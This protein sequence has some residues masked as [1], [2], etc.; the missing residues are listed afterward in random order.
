MV[1]AEEFKPGNY[2]L[3]SSDTSKLFK[4]EEIDLTKE[5]SIKI[6]AVSGELEDWYAPAGTDLLPAVLSED[7]LISF[8][9]KK[10][11][12]QEDRTP[13]VYTSF[14]LT[15]EDGKTIHLGKTENNYELVPAHHVEK[16]PKMKFVHKLQNLYEETTGKKL[17]KR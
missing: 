3:L 4:V 15:L 9:F 17:E 1:R 12:Y 10:D 6:K 13:Y 8:G 2:I 16:F 11:V 7:W 14:I 5:K